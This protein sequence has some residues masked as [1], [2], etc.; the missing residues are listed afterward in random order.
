MANRTKTTFDKVNFISLVL[1]S[2]LSA[3]LVVGV[4]EI[5]ARISKGQPAPPAPLQ[6]DLED[7]AE[8]VR[9]LPRTPSSESCDG[10][11]SR[12]ILQCSTGRDLPDVTSAGSN[13][14]MSPE[15]EAAE[16]AD[17]SAW[18][19]PPKN[20]LADMATRCEIRSVAPA[21][22]ESQVPTVDDDSARA[23]ALSPSER[24]ELDQTLRQMHQSFAESVQ[25]IYAEGTGDPNRGSSLFLDQMINDIQN[26]PNSGLDQARQTLALERAGMAT[27]P[28]TDA[29]LPPG[30]RLL[31]RSAGLGD[32]FERRLADRLG[33]DRARQLLFSPFAGPWT[34]RS[35]QSGCWA[36]E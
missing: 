3:L 22:T 18:A 14:A 23:L 29:T 32:D 10:L 8:A 35:T 16:I 19:H 6:S 12:Y 36:A 24:A 13:T 5:R 11:R 2:A 7:R 33:A 1:A 28:A 27:P 26:R 15:H 31:R 20:Q 30:E 4:Y 9:A 34:T 21:V 25:Q 17:S